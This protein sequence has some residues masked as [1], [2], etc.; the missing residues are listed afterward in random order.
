MSHDHFFP[1]FSLRPAWG[2]RSLVGAGV[3]VEEAAII[4]ARVNRLAGHY[5]K[6]TPA[7]QVMEIVQHIPRALEEMLNENVGIRERIY[8]L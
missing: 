3:E 4:G 6:P 7:T 8:A 5:A 1:F 2:C